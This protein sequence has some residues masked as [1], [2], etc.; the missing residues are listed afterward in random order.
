MVEFML[1]VRLTLLFNYGMIVSLLIMFMLHVAGCRLVATLALDLGCARGSLTEYCY[2]HA[3]YFSQV[4]SKT[5]MAT[6]DVSLGDLLA[7]GWRLEICILF[8]RNRC[9]I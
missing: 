8:I 9:I 6:L 3:H 4:N 2:T 7:L 5:E 1:I